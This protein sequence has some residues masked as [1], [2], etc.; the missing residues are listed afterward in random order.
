VH[1]KL[2]HGNLASREEEGR[3]G[4]L[5]NSAAAGLKL[6]TST[7]RT[8]VGMFSSKLREDPNTSTKAK[9]KPSIIIFSI[10]PCYTLAE[11]LLV[12]LAVSREKQSLST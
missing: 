7:T 11:V 9:S 6:C 5:Y 8:R 10:T 12:I 4:T 2:H 3:W 1:P